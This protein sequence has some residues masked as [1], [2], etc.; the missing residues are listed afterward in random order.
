MKYDWRDA[1]HNVYYYFRTEDALIVGQA[2]NIA[3]T[4]I[5]IAIAIHIN[6]E[7]NLGRYITLDGAKAALQRYWDI[8]E[9][10]LLE[11]GNV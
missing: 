8:Q 4:K 5:W 2:H 3:Y 6:E 7:R 1:E 11:N 10:T 9:R